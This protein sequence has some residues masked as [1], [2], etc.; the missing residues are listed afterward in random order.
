MRYIRSVL[1]LIS[2]SFLVGWNNYCLKDPDE[3]IN[4]QEYPEVFDLVVAIKDHLIGSCQTVFNK[5]VDDK[6]LTWGEYN[7]LVECYNRSQT[8]RQI[9]QSQ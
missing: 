9:H 7:R 4:Q 2:L 6:K 3:V 8:I 5:M 1:L